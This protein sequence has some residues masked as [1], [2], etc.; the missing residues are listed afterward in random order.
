MSGGTLTVRSATSC[1]L[2][3]AIAQ[4][5]R[6]HVRAA[7]C[8]ASVGPTLKFALFAKTRKDRRL[9]TC[10]PRSPLSVHGT[11]GQGNP[12]LEG[13]ATQRRRRR[14]QSFCRGRRA[15][16]GR[17]W[18]MGGAGRGC[19][20]I[21]RRGICSLAKPFSHQPPPMFAQRPK[22]QVQLTGVLKLGTRATEKGSTPASNGPT[23]G[24]SPLFTKW[25]PLCPPGPWA[26]PA[27]AHLTTIVARLLE[28]EIS[29][30]AR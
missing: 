23:S 7:R 8:A 18:V 16:D 3:T 1:Q 26:S 20:V 10:V 11:D 21:A 6:W 12:Q 13:P 15:P 27:G 5:A 29:V 30:T 14:N 19:W 28:S 2:H 24:G 4:G 9:G 17:L 22:A 25:S